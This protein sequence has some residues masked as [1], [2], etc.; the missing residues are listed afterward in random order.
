MGTGA[1]LE[2]NLP[3]MS[4][5]RVWTNTL[6]L[7]AQIQQETVAKTG[8]LRCKGLFRLFETVIQGEATI[9]ARQFAQRLAR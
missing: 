7:A 2:S 9:R 4:R 5:A 3:A 1:R 8:P 6:T